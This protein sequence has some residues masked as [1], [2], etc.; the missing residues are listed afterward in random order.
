MGYQPIHDGEFYIADYDVPTVL[1]SIFARK[2]VLVGFSDDEYTDGK[3]VVY[4]IRG[5]R[6]QFVNWIREFYSKDDPN[7][8]ADDDELWHEFQ[9][10]GHFNFVA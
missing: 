4:T 6:R 9:D 8:L 2:M 3:G 7:I 5:T 1:K 10:G